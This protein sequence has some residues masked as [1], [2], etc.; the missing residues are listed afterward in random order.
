MNKSRYHHVGTTFPVLCFLYYVLT[1]IYNHFKIKKIPRDTKNKK[2][3]PVYHS[4]L[5]DQRIQA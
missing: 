4:C 5:I 1:Q 2:Y 3:C